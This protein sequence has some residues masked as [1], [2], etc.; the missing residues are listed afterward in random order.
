MMNLESYLLLAI[1]AGLL[2]QTFGKQQ[3]LPF[4]RKIVQENMLEK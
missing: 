2:N 4:A 1:S 3:V